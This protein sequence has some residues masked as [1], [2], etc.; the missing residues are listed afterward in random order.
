MHVNVIRKN[1]LFSPDPSR[2]IPRFLYTT[3]GRSIDIINT[4]L[5]MTDTEVNNTFNPL[6]RDFSTR[7]R[8][9][10][11]TF[12]RHFDKLNPIFKFLKIDENELSPLRRALIGS[13]FTMEYSIESAAF[14]NPS[15]MEDPDQS[16]LRPD[17]KRVVFSF[18]ATGEGHISSIVFRTGVLDRNNNLTLEPVGKLLAEADVSKQSV[19]NKKAFTLKLDE[20]QDQVYT[21]PADFILDKLGDSF[22]YGELLHF[23]N[24]TDATQTTANEKSIIQMMLMASSHYE[25]DFSIDS[26]IS[27]RVIFPISTNEQK[28]I[29]DARFVKFTDDN[30]EITYYAVYTANDGINVIPKLI[31][32]TDFYK[33]EIL[34]MYGETLTNKGMALFP[35]KINGKYAMLCQVDGV[36]NFIAYSD[37]LNNWHKATLIQE[38]KYPWE[39]LQTGN[40]GSPIE[41][42]A[43][44]LVLT[45]GVGPMNKCV[46]S[47][48]LFDIDNP[49]KE[50]GRLS[51]PLIM[52]NESE[53]EGF[54]PNVIYSCGSIIHGE[55]LVIPYSISNHTATYATVNLKELLIELKGIENASLKTT[56]GLVEKRVIT[57]R[58]SELKVA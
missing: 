21:L 39:L 54:V 56:L 19:Y 32:T 3:E 40:A 17:E 7:H 27:E 2:I 26:A 25:I 22:T 28:G 30:E 41:T 52:P 15:I 31:K 23:L 45:H 29:E 38:P 37:N 13:Y 55:D 58:Q 24:E 42:E 18:R 43:G 11:K 34:P 47:A 10:T 12:S 6:L 14:Y 48:S 4:V 8:N 50:T 51:M 35:R 16:G 36:S 44:W 57:V 9:I 1:T 5:A 20:M 33:F 53:R 49:E 46:I